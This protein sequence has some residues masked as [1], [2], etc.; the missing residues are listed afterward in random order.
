MRWLNV[1]CLMWGHD[2]RIQ[3]VAGRMYLECAECGRETDGW[4][5]TSDVIV[6]DR[7]TSARS[8]A[9]VCRQFWS[10]ARRNPFA[11]VGLR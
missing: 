10:Q 4:N 6:S 7:P 3:R 9:H 2:D 11:A 5:V 1:R 8:W